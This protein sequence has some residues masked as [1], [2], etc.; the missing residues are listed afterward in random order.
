MQIVNKLPNNGKPNMCSSIKCISIRRKN[1]G[2]LLIS[3]KL[4]IL[5]IYLGLK[6]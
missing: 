5:F 4:S 2:I 6:C 3:T 1:Q